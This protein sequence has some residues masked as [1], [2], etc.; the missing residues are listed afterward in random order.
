MLLFVQKRFI[1]H[2]VA[3]SDKYIPTCWILRP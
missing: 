3:F 2:F 1:L